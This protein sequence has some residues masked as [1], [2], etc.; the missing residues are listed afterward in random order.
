MQNKP[1]Q[2]QFI[3]SLPKEQTQ[4]VLSFSNGSNPVHSPPRKIPSV[5]IHERL[6]IIT[7]SIAAMNDSIKN[8]CELCD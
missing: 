1:K 8:L 2:T 7:G 4:P 5:V 6:I 3:L